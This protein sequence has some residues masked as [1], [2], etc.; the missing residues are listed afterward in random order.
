MRNALTIPH[1][2]QYLHIPCLNPQ[3]DILFLKMDESPIKAGEIVV[4]NIDVSAWLNVAFMQWESM[5]GRHA[6][7][8]PC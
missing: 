8:K 5:A 4:F 2:S 7:V 6:D 3:G 1:A